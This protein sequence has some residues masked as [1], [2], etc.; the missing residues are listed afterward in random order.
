M[1]KET[2]NLIQV[3][4]LCFNSSPC[5]YNTLSTWEEYVDRFCV[6]INNG[7]IDDWNDLTNTLNELK[8]LKKPV[9][10]FFNYFENFSKTRNKLLD[11]SDDEGYHSI[12]IDDT[13]ELKYF[14]KNFRPI[15]PM[16]INIE[17]NGWKYDS[18]RIIPSGCKVRYKFS[19]HEILDTPFKSSSGILVKDVDYDYHKLRRINRCNYDLINLGNTPRDLYY[20]ATTLFN[21]YKYGKVSRE[22]VIKA[23]DERMKLNIGNDSEKYLLNL[24]LRRI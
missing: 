16:S 3:L 20:R 21:M 14:P 4:C 9:K 24:I 2:N 11:L 13:Y 19:V 6:L 7:Y 5:I 8:K 15:Y 17:N 12:F 18:C 10:I 23:I 22:E 1:K